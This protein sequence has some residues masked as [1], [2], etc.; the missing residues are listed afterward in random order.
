M[1]FK[2]YKP[3][4]IRGVEKRMVSDLIHY[5][6]SFKE[7]TGLTDTRIGREALN[8]ANFLLD[9]RAGTRRLTAEKYDQLVAWFDTK[10]EEMGGRNGAAHS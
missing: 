8:D 4:V 3:A 2:P 7:H 10:L 5:A 9:I 6:D 1:A